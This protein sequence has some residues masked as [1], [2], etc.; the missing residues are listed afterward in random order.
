MPAYY[1]KKESRTKGAALNFKRAFISNVRR[2][3]L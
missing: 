1:C 2:K 3:H